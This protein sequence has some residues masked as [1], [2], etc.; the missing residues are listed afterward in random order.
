MNR[1]VAISL[2]SLLS[3]TGCKDLSRFD[4][5]GDHYEGDVISG[6]FVRAGV[7]STTRACLTF[8]T[9]RLQDAP[10]S[11][12]T[13]DGRFHNVALRAIPQ[14]WHDKLSTLS[15][16]SDEERTLLY[17]ATPFAPAVDGGF[18]AQ[19]EADSIVIVSLMRTGEIEL[20]LLRGAPLDVNTI[21]T[22]PELPLF[23]VFHLAR[24]PG[25]CS[26]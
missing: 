14:V 22:A 19:K 1:L 21:E 3:T 9:L 10:G 26:F 7:D 15:L 23:A 4:N 8:D 20:R 18:S 11:L 25:A 5:Q 6:R 2:V 17:A 12:T 13:S 16:S 24:K